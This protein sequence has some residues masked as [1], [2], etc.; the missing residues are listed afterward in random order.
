[1]DSSGRDETVSD[2][3]PFFADGAL[4]ASDVPVDETE[5]DDVVYGT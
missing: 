2:E 5:I 3:D 1:M 4:F